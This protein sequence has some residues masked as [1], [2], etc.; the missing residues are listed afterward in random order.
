MTLIVIQSAL[1]APMQGSPHTAGTTRPDVEH[2]VRGAD[3]A[4]P[5]PRI[6]HG[7]PATR[8]EWPMSGALLLTGDATY[9][10]F[11]L[12]EQGTVICTST[13]IAPDVVL[14]AAHCVDPQV[15]EF[16][17]QIQG[18][19]M[20][21]PGFLW[22]R[23]PDLSAYQFGLPVDRFPDDAVQI[24]AIVVHEDWSFLQLQLGLADNHDIALAFLEEPVFDVPLGYLPQADTAE[25]EL[26]VDDEVVVVGWGQ[27]SQSAPQAP[28]NPNEV[29]TKQ[30]G[31][32]H[33]ERVR[34]F[35]FQVGGSAQDVRKCHGDSGGPTF[36]QV[37]TDSSDEWRV[38]GVTSHSYDQTDCVV[39]GGVDTR[40]SHH[41]DWIDAE[42][43]AACADGT[44]AWCEIEGIIPPPFPD[45]RLAWELPEEGDEGKGCGC[46]AAPGAPGVLLAGLPL[47]GLLARRRTHRTE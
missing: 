2:P 29:G 9:Q 40:V 5:V 25:V 41:L 27:Q 13:L 45:G 39:T 21:D 11:D 22:T 34:A 38:V 1:A 36:K 28:A 37:P 33:V 12:G 4:H 26:E 7:E 19:S 15:L 46:Q 18:V 6:I 14:L 10:G 20:P 17:L 30:M 31:V 16:Q 32:S 43:R 47:L 44:R 23:R 35:E 8:E 24:A 42:M 3:A